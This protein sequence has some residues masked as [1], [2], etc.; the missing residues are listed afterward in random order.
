MLLLIRRPA[1]SLPA[2]GDTNIWGQRR[3]GA[4]ELD[5]VQYGLA[6]GD[7]SQQNCRRR[8]AEI[9]L[10]WLQKYDSFFSIRLNSFP[11]RAV[12]LVRFISIPLFLFRHLQLHGHGYEDAKAPIAGKKESYTL[13]ESLTNAGEVS[14]GE[15]E[16]A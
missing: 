16:I 14:I 2:P 9:H 7:V 11:H 10:R 5:V 6:D 13:E 12:K 8:N 1:P 15:I 4:V 3:P